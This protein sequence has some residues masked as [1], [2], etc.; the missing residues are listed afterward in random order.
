MS[1]SAVLYGIQAVGYLFLAGLSFGL[2]YPWASGRMAKALLNNVWLG[3]RKL[4]LSGSTEQLY[5][6]FLLGLLGGLIAI[7]L[8]FGLNFSLLFSDMRGL[9]AFA[10]IAVVVFFIFLI[11][12]VCSA[13]YRAAFFRWL[14]EHASF[15]EARTR[16]TL[17]GAQ[18]FT[19][20]LTNLALIICTLG[21]GTAWAVIRAAKARLDSILHQGDPQL[22]AL[23]Q[24]AKDAPRSGEGLLDALDVDIAL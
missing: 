17:S 16:S 8:L 15:G 14:F 1:G 22:D 11:F 7:I 3:N 9:P 18:L 13:F 12:S 19:L 4:A 23:L 21:L 5:T 24:D 2:L 10:H 6:T 20:T